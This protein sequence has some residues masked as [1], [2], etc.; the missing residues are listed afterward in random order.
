MLPSRKHS[1]VHIPVSP[2]QYQAFRQN[3][4]PDKLPGDATDWIQRPR[5]YRQEIWTHTRKRLLQSRQAYATVA[6]YL[7]N[8]PIWPPPL[9]EQNR[10]DFVVDRYDP[11]KEV[12]TFVL[13]EFSENYTEITEMLTVL[14]EAAPYARSG[15]AGS[16]ALYSYEWR[17]GGTP[18]EKVSGLMQKPLCFVSAF[19]G[20]SGVPAAMISARGGL[21][22]VGA[23]SP[24]R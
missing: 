23:A 17:L 1:I 20:R 15:E 7:D 24:P 8:W 4:L 5:E 13:W 9:T 6:D 21:S 3:P 16:I 11:E 22:T 18:D 12:W 2:K 19:H 14:R 10:H